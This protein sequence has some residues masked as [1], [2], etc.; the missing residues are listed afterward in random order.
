M[1]QLIL[2][3]LITLLLGCSKSLSNGKDY[4][5]YN[6]TDRRI[7]EEYYA[8]MGAAEATRIALEQMVECGADEDTTQAE[9]QA[10]VQKVL[11]R[12]A[13]VSTPY[14][15]RCLAW[16]EAV[17]HASETTCVFGVVVSTYKDS[18]SNAFFIDFDKSR[19]SF[20]AVSFK[21]VWNGLE[22]RCVEIYGKIS[23]H[24]GRPQI[25]IENSEQVRACQK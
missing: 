16:T 11:G 10:C 3:G 4:S 7:S 19:R 22:G 13:S 18:N 8:A 14:A 24:N 2:L 23:T 20:Y 12:S 1:K 25:V 5:E 9:Y 15:P 6:P 21:S 17:R